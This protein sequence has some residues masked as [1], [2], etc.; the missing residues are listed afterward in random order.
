MK[1]G[2]VLMCY[3]R[4]FSYWLQGANDIIG[5]HYRYE[6]RRRPDNSFK[7]R[8]IYQSDTIHRK[9]GYVYASLL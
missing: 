5:G 9:I 3:V 8:R 7:G 2:A 6:T 1:E 4:Q